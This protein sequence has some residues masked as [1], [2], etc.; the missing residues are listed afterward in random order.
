MP[1]RA[2]GLP[3]QAAR[4]RTATRCSAP[5][6]RS[7]TSR[8]ACRTSPTCSAPTPASR[9][10]ANRNAALGNAEPGRPGLPVLLR[11]SR[12][13]SGRR[14]HPAR[15]SST[16]SREVITGDLNIF[17]PDLQVPYSQTLDR[18]HPPQDHAR[19][20]RRRALRRH[21]P[22]A[23]LD[24][25]Q[26]QRSE[27]HRERLPQ[28]VPA[29]RRPT[30]RRTS[31]PA[32][33]TRFALLRARHRH[34]A[35]ADLSRATSTASPAAQRGR[36]RA[37]TPA[38]SWTNTN[39]TNPLA[40]LQPE[41]R[42]RRPA[43]TRTPA[44]TAT[45]RGAPTRWR[46]AC[47]RTSSAP[48]RISRAA[49]H[50]PATAAT[51]ATTR[52]RSKSASACR[53]ASRAGQLRVRQ[54]LHLDPAT[55]FR[56]PRYET[57]QTGDERRHHARAQGELGV[58]AAVRPAAARFLANSQRPGRSPGRR[59]GVRRHRPHPERPP[60]RLRQRAPRRHDRRRSCRT[61]SSS[62]STR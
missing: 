41:R 26:L 32:A 8:T 45:R 2:A 43:P 14:Q 39:F 50:R 25:L 10:T 28:R 61:P 37:S 4:R 34:V 57:L 13:A 35:A 23:G 24:R 31:R 3:R 16:R 36:R 21:A 44:S 5:A 53:T 60:A 56:L 42:S 48:T 12:R 18:R 51:P 22:P 20:R 6:T 58:R 27:H 40:R 7:P 38:A 15:R 46:R 1:G 9:S 55:R 52:C 62:R 29:A 33:A 30:C 11:D 47:P 19:H 54:R 17:D 49:A 59:L